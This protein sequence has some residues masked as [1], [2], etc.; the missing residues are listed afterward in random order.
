MPGL[1]VVYFGMEL[2]RPHFSL[3][4]FDGGHRVGRTGHQVEAGGKF[5]CF[6]AVRHPDGK[7]CG[8]AFEETGAVLD[9]DLGMTVL[10]LVGGAHLAAQRVHHELESVADAKHGQAQLEHARIGG[11]RVGVIHRRGPAGKNDACRRVAANFFQRGGAGKHDG[12]DILFTDAA[13]DELGI[14]RAEIEDDDGLGF[15]GRVSQI[16][17]GV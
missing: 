14:L 11:R 13:R 1:G 9:F 5:H 7:F 8:Q 17:G 2:H 6:V 12:K 10:A 15:H 3:G 4:G 16:V